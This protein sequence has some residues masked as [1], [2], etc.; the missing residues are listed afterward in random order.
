MIGAVAGG[1]WST[2]HADLVPGQ[3]GL[4]CRGRSRAARLAMID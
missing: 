3:G 2:A 1:T 4:D